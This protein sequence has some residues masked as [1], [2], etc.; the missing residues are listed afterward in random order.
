MTLNNIYMEVIFEKNDNIL[1]TYC[2]DFSQAK[3]TTF[4]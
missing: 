1:Q 4:Q 3:E 2:L